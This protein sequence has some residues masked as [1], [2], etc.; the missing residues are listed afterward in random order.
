MR[1][2]KHDVSV[3]VKLVLYKIGFVCWINGKC[4]KIKL[5]KKGVLVGV[6]V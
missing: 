5:C 4:D 6:V 1:E 3:L 2:N